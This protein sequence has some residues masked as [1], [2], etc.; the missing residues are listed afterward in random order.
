MQQIVAEYGSW[1]LSILTITVMVLAGRKHPWTWRIGLG[2]QFL[3]LGWIACV[4][5]PAYGL[6]PTSVALIY[7]YW[8]NDRKWRNEQV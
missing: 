3:W 2:A 5:Q 8:D 1:L 7:V 6:I 4:G